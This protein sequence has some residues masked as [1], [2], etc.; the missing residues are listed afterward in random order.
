MPGDWQVGAHARFAEAAL[1]QQDLDLQFRSQP[2]ANLAQGHTV[3]V[4]GQRAAERGA[5]PLVR[6]GSRFE[7]CND[8]LAPLRDSRS[9]PRQQGF[10]LRVHFRRL[11]QDEPAGAER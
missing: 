2:L 5:N 8:R 9:Q 4:E 11:R 10:D 6:R 1:V 7:V 3:I